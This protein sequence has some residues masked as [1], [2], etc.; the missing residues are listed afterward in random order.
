MINKEKLHRCKIFFGLQFNTSHNFHMFLNKKDGCKNFKRYIFW[1]GTHL[2]KGANIFVVVFNCLFFTPAMVTLEVKKSFYYVI[3][4]IPR[5]L[6]ESR[7]S[8][9]KCHFHDVITE[10][11]SEF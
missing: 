8:N 4:R 2:W 10:I 3:P 11:Y 1:S 5:T 9:S 7:A 6:E